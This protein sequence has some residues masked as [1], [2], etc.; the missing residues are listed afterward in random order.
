MRCSMQDVFLSGM[1]EV[2][3]QRTLHPREQRAADCITRCYSPALGSRVLS[4]PEGHFLSVQHH[5]CRHRSCPRC[6]VGAQ[7]KWVQAQLQQLLP[8][9]HFHVIFTLP[10]KL[11]ALWE[12]NREALTQLM[13]DCVREC[14]LEM[15]AQPRHLGAMPA[16]LMSLHTWGRNLSRHP[17]LHCLV[18]AGGLDAQGQWRGT[19]HRFLLPIKA[20]QHL[21]RGKFLARLGILL[22]G[23]SLNLP[24]RQDAHFWLALRRELYRQHWNVQ[25]CEPYAHGRGVAVYLARYVKGGPLPKSR[26]LYLDDGVVRFE[27]T[28]HRDQR[29]KTMR[30]AT[31]EFISR[32]LWHAPPKGQHT[33]RRAGLYASAHREQ[34]QHCQHLLSPTPEPQPLHPSAAH[35]FSAPAPP[36]IAWPRCPQCN[37]PLVEHHVRPHLWHARGEISLNTVSSASGLGP[38][39]RSTGP[40][41]AAPRA[42]P[43]LARAA[44]G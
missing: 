24:P 16:L 37:L 13:F 40:P 35:D 30:L 43:A 7:H 28:D 15:L 42:W 41:P 8:C 20:L 18:S 3:Q 6:C 19:A 10:H 22:K 33:V 39:S 26:P 32:V 36:A 34:H 25:I 21:F 31:P 5:A 23:A 2:S 9:P 14:L 38:T 27:Y 44:A 4:C 29:V 11:L 12:F 1:H 17:H